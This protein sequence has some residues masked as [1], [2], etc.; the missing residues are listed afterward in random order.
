MNG[1]HA[2]S[3]KIGFHAPTTRYMHSEHARDYFAALNYELLP[4]F[5]DKDKARILV[6]ERLKKFSLSDYFLFSLLNI[7]KMGGSLS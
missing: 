1:D 5:I 2:F 4:S 3:K 6:T 7:H